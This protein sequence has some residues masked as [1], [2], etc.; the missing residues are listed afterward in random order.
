MN[1]K[2]KALK[3]V[4]HLKVMDMEKRRGMMGRKSTME[5]IRKVD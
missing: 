5:T 3:K 1:T 2:G 4:G